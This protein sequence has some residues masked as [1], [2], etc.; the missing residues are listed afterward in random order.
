MFHAPTPDKNL[1]IGRL[2]FVEVRILLSAPNRADLITQMV[3]K[4]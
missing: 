2:E 1:A 3:K 4:T